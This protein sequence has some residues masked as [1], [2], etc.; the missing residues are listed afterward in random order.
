MKKIVF[1]FIFLLITIFGVFKYLEREEANNNS[2]KLR[3]AEVTH[4]LFYTPFYVA[5]E[6][7]YFEEED[8]DIELI[9]TSGADK[10]SAAVLSGDVEIGFAGPESSIY[11]YNWGEKDYI[12]NFAGLTKRDG[13]FIV[14]REKINNFT[15]DNLI[16]KE[17]LAGRVGGMPIINFYNALNNNNINQDEININTSVE[18]AALAGNF[19]AGT[20]DFVNL[21]E[22]TATK[23]EN[24]GLGY[25]V[26]SVGELSGVVPY[27]A[28][29][30]KKSFL[31]E[32]KDLLKRFT[33]AL[34]KGIKFVKENDNKIIAEIVMPQFND[35]SIEEIETIIKRYKDSDSWFESPFID[36]DSFENLKEMMKK[37]SLLDKD[38]SYEDLVINLYEK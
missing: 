29:N 11:V 36:E 17:I 3:V 6:N 10:V 20:G 33:I 25:V 7:G 12:V 31:E 35:S 28:F 27:T 4:S 8:I 15:L 37:N 22:P 38:V 5:I 26:A 21:F 19:I 9:L 34:D 30:T 13:Q 32:N 18:F 14:S 2:V 1:L 16:G 23:L 24:E